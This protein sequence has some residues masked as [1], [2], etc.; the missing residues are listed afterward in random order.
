M[1]YLSRISNH[2]DE[3]SYY[4]DEKIKEVKKEIVT[5]K[6]QTIAMEK[7]INDIK[8]QIGIDVPKQIISQKLYYV[9]DFIKIFNKNYLEQFAEELKI[10]KINTKSEILIDVFDNLII[11]YEKGS[12]TE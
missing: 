7:V 6:P 1:Y 11:N 12:D 9:M 3:T 2:Q 8:R 5:I 4:G 10:H